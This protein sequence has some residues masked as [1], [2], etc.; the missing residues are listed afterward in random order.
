MPGPDDSEMAEV[1]R[2]HLRDAKPLG[3]GDDTGVD[4]AEPEIGVGVDEFG[5]RCQS[6]GVIFSTAMSPF[7]TER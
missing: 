4:T 2:R 7:T 1:E 3:H 5:D 6:A